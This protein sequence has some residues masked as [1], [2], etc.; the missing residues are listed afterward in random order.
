[1]K[2]SVAVVSTVYQRDSSVPF[3]RAVDVETLFENHSHRPDKAQAWL[4]YRNVSESCSAFQR[5]VMMRG[6]FEGGI[7]GNHTYHWTF[8]PTHSGDLAIVLPVYEDFLLV[9]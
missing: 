5:A 8:T 3:W 4:R 6:H 1:M 2:E 7:L 9:D